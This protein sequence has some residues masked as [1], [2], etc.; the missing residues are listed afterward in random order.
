M[1]AFRWAAVSCLLL[2][3]IGLLLAA[4]IS[5]APALHPGKRFTLTYTLE[6]LAGRWV[7]KENQIGSLLPLLTMAAFYVRH[8]L[9][10]K[11]GTRM[12][13]A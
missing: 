1:C 10:V 13:T 2:S 6:L 7:M 3:A 11:A 8:R 12:K 5:I 4:H 9:L